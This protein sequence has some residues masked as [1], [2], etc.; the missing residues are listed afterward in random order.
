MLNRKVF[1]GVY[2][3]I[4][5][6]FWIWMS[7]YY[8]V[9]LALRSWVG[10]LLGLLVAVFACWR[11]FRALANPID[12]SILRRSL[13]LIGAVSASVFLPAITFLV[14]ITGFDHFRGYGVEPE[15]ILYGLVRERPN[16]GLYATTWA[17]SA[18]LLSILNYYL[19]FWVLWRFLALTGVV[20]GRIKQRL[21]G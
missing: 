1:S 8:H 16:L 14:F 6:C 2:V 11:L 10:A 4:F 7:T 21:V 13:T 20:G 9:V 3:G 15:E 18:M 12:Q 17:S 19:G 5:F